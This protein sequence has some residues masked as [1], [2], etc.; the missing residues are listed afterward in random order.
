VTV[1]VDTRDLEMASSGGA[2]QVALEPEAPSTTKLVGD[3]PS[4]QDEETT[5]DVDV[6]DEDRGPHASTLSYRE[7]T[8]LLE[9]IRIMGQENAEY[10]REAAHDPAN[11]GVPR[12]CKLKSGPTYSPS[13]TIK[14]TPSGGMKNAAFDLT[15]EFENDLSTGAVPSCCE[16]R[17]F[18]SWTADP[19][20]NH[21]GFQPAANFKANTWYE[22]RDGVGKRY[23]HRTGPHAEC[24]GINHYED[25]AG[26]QDCATG[27]I[28]K[29]HDAPV[30]AG[31]RTGQW[32]FQLK[33]I[34]ACNG[35]TDVGTAASVN[36]SWDP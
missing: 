7:S 10:C 18:I 23:G 12:K 6:A 22:D 9:C 25:S 1:H 29:G 36:V 30:G 24:I 33:A 20:P 34:D 26:T 5:M 8:E 27:A 13:G 16:V 4:D 21:A 2:Q 31:T 35:G 17:Q 14:A 19:P 32:R 11:W 15:A 3:G 28:Y